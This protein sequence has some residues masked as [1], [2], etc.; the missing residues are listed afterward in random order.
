MSAR[1][2]LEMAGRNLCRSIERLE[3]LDAQNQDR[4]RAGPGRP[5][6]LGLTAAQFHLLTEGLFL[7]LFRSYE[8]FMEEC[9]LVCMMSRG[10]LR[11]VRPFVA[12]RDVGHA[13]SMLKGS[14]RFVEWH[15]PDVII[16][17]SEL[18]FN[19]GGLIKQVVSSNRGVLFEMKRVRDRIAHSS[20]EAETQ[21]Q[22]VLQARLLT[23]TTRIPP[24]GEFL[25]TSV[26]NQPGLYHLKLYC[27]ETRQISDSLSR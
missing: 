26:R 15:S 17:R 27:L 8:Q 18:Y 25:Q 20:R 4:Y 14:G 16:A 7:H 1:R 23:L 22:N 21:F 12:P 2:K 24:P 11:S 9:F 3:A 13:R 10:S 6:R 19:N 5:A